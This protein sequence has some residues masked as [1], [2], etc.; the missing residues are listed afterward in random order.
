MILI[1]RTFT[2]CTPA[3][4]ENGDFEDSGFLAKDES[5]SFRELVD[6]LK[7]HGVPSCSPA[8]GDTF[9]WYASGFDVVDYSTG[10]ERETAVHFSRANPP[11][12]AKYWEKAAR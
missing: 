9:E 5:V 2:D 11:R 12:V 3:S 1:N 7:C 4:A 8:S 6:L 10:R